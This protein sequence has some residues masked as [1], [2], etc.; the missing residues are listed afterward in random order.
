MFRKS[1]VLTTAILV[2]AGLFLLSGIGMAAEVSPKPKI[3]APC[4][5]CHAP[6]EK[7][8]RGSFAGISKK[9]GTVQIQ[10]GPA[11]WLVKFGDDTKLTGA[12]KFSAIPKDKEIAIAITEKDGSLYAAGLSVKP[13]AKV[14][15]EKLMAAEELARLV[16]A[17]AEKGNFTLVDSRPG[18]RYNEGHIPGAISIYDADFD[19]DIEKLPKDKDK[20]LIF[21]CAGP[22]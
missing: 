16:S 13:P 3:A 11:S 5:Q 2:A 18:A 15:P 9:A 8:L 17:G 22:T 21:Y 1:R 10:I 6:D 4:K 14:A 20:L 12:E 7:I 19:K